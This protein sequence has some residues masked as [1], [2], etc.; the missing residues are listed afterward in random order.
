MKR[1]GFTMIELLV[2]LGLLAVLLSLL[3]PA[4]LSARGAAGLLGC[5]DRL[6]Q[7]GVAASAFE[8]SYRVLPVGGTTAPT[9]GLEVSGA[10][11]GGL[12]SDGFSYSQDVLSTWVCPADPEALTENSHQ[13]YR[14]VSGVSPDYVDLG[15]LPATGGGVV[16]RK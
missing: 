1:R 9:Y 6:R 8:A 13:S 12:P 4:L 16:G 3:M 10:L 11:S 7:I 14:M 2:C 15:V 5:S